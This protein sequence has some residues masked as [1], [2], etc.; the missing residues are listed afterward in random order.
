[1]EMIAWLGFFSDELVQNF[2]RV[3][4]TKNSRSGQPIA[5]QITIAVGPATIGRLMRLMFRL[6]FSSL[7]RH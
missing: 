6:I 3:L 2:C 4:T 1:M 5:T 7:N